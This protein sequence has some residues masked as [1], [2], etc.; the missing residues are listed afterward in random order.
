MFQHGGRIKNVGI[1][2]PLRGNI[3]TFQYSPFFTNVGG[4]WNLGIES[5]NVPTFLIST[6]FQLL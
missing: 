4:F 6:Q 1:G 2:I 3:P 5:W